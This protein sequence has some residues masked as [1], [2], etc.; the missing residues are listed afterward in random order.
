MNKPEV[1]N[2]ILIKIIGILTLL[3]LI[4]FGI[5]VSI[6]NDYN[7]TLY[8]DNSVSSNSSDGTSEIISINTTNLESESFGT[9][10]NLEFIVDVTS[11]DVCDNTYCGNTAT[12]DGYSGSLKFK[13]SEALMNRNDVPI[14]IGGTYIITTSPMIEL[15]ENKLPLVTTTSIKLAT[16]EDINR[17]EYI[18]S[19]V[20]TFKRKI[21][22]YRSMELKDIINDANNSYPAWT[23]NEIKEYLK[24]IEEMGYTNDMEFRS[25]VCLRED[26]VK[27]YGK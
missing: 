23:Q 26:I 4:L 13:F 10:D 19:E 14:Y 7:N 2:E 15:D 12:K 21:I 20:S 17:L 3:Y 6:V 11:V 1:I 27:V 18:K 8:I 16:D 22:E 25:F 24:L 9:L 5:R